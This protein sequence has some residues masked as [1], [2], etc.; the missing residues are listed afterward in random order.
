MLIAFALAATVAT[1][2]EGSTLDL[3]LDCPG[4]KKE[5]VAEQI[6]AFGRTNEGRTANAFGQ[7]THEE[8]VPRRAKLIIHGA[9]ATL[10]YGEGT[11][12]E[13]KNITVD[14]EMIRGSYRRLYTTSISVDR[15]TGEMKVFA[16]K[17]SIPD[18]VGTC[19]PAKAPG[20]PKF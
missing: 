16:G 11:V 18:F 6:Q 13:I 10:D 5:V 15:R 17:T 19:E 2:A 20:P 14:A 4:Y 3:S 8:N 1:S 7:V 9:H 12:R